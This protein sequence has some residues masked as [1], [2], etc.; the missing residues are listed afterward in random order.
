MEGIHL[1]A[2]HGEKTNY[3]IFLASTRR[4]YQ[5]K[6]QTLVNGAKLQASHPEYEEYEDEDE[7]PEEDMD[8]EPD[9]ED[10]GYL[11]VDLHV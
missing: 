10:P 2:L 11:H 8:E 5:K 1:F 4:V 3:S 6:L 7:Y 9:E